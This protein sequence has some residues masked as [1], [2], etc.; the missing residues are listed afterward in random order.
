M[1]NIQRSVQLASLLVF[2]STCVISSSL[3][4]ETWANKGLTIQN[5]LELWLDASRINEAR[6]GKSAAIPNGG[7]INIWPDA[8]GNKRHVEQPLPA[9]RPRYFIGDSGP[10]VR[11]DG[12]NDFLSAMRLGMSLT[13][14]TI[15]IRATPRSNKD[16]FSAFVAVNESGANDFAT[17][18]NIDMGTGSATEL[19]SINVEGRTFTGMKDMLGATVPFGTTHTFTITSAPGEKGVQVWMDGI[20]QGNRARGA[21]AS[22]MDEITIGARFYSNTPEPA[23]VQN[24]LDG[25]IAEIIIYSRILSDAERVDLEK[26]LSSKTP[27]RVEGRKLSPLVAVTNVPPVQVLVSGFTVRQL[28]IDLNNINCV[29]YRDDGKLVALGYDGNIWLLSDKDGDGLE[30]TATPFWNKQTLNAPIGLALTPPGYAKGRGVFVPAKK[31]VVLIVDTNA[32][33]VA[34]EEIVIAKDWPGQAF[35]HGVDSLGIAADKDGSVYFGV[36]TAN[37]ADAYLRDKEGKSRYDVK[38]ERSTIMKIAPDFSHREI[39]CTGIRFPVALAINGQGDLFCTDQEGATWLPNGNPFDELLHI[40]RD[41]HYGFP[42][43]HP[44]LLPNVLDEPSTFDYAPQHQSA[45][46]LNFNEPVV[47]GGGTFGP[48]WWKGDAFVCGYSRGKIWRTKLVKTS[49][50][51]VAQNQLI[52][53]LN[54]LTVDACV[55]PKGDLVVSVHSGAPDWGSGPTGKGK[56][57]KIS[58]DHKAAPQPV[59]IYPSSE[60][61]TRIEFDRALDPA[62]FKNLTKQIKIVQGRYAAAG[63]QFEVLRPGYQVVQDQMA[64]MR[65]ELEVQ[66]AAIDADGRTLVVRTAP[67]KHAIAYAVT[68]P[69]SQAASG[70]NA[71]PQVATTDL[72]HDLTG[73]QGTWSDSRGKMQWQGWLPHLNT[74]VAK[75]FT[76][77]AASHTSLWSNLQKNGELRLKGRLDL[78]LMLRTAVQPGAKLD[79]EYPNE[80]VTV[81][82]KSKVPLTVTAPGSTVQRLS[83]TETHL[84]VTS[85]RHAWTAF[86]VV[87]KTKQG[88]DP[89]LE[90]SWFTAEYSRQRSI[91]LRRIFLPFAEPEESVTPTSEE[92]KIPELAGGNWLRGQK[93]F[94]GEQASCSKCHSMSGRGA[95]IGPDLSNLS[96]RD[97]ASVVKDITQPSAAINP[98]HVS[99][100]VELKNGDSFTGLPVPGTD[101]TIA[102]I[103]AGLTN[104]VS[105]DAVASMKPSPISLMPEG[106]LEG[107]KEQQR[108]DLLTFLLMP[109]PLSPAELE[110]SGEPTPQRRADIATLVAAKAS[111]K[112]KPLRIL[113]AA[114]P[115]DHGPGEHDYPLWQKRWSKLLPL[116]ENVTID[117]SMEWPTAEQFSKSDVIVFYSNNPGWSAGRASE[118]D[119]FLN[120]GGGLVYIHYAV[121]GHD[122]CNELAQR[123]GLAWRGGGSRFRHGPLDLK[124]TANEI[125]AG[126]GE[127]KLIDESYWQ[128]VG[129]ESSI[130]ILASGVE[131]GSPRPLIWTKEQGK[132]R[133]F[134]SIPGHYTWTFDDPLFRLLLLR[135]IAWSAHQPVDRLA[136]LATIGARISE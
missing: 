21:E 45:C 68:L 108:K 109:A 34:D 31:K 89:D 35:E 96:H 81:V 65:Y 56:L 1:T 42:P 83:D 107:L 37:F 119:A 2:I 135:G 88:I 15:F 12:T 33:D 41:K 94:F 25:D 84:T 38:G 101:G 3:A 130:K 62:E 110:I 40:E 87:L 29:K 73:V 95:T 52:A 55:A 63:D 116:A 98:D 123:I 124:L 133:V 92:R 103:G 26:Y 99:Y 126:L 6:Q 85:A 112:Q 13:N 51:Y 114:G 27:T 102:I 74:K 60:T 14:S 28:P 106:L 44:K 115:K 64:E 18:L 120:R 30:D 69:R 125:T 118:L 67:R 79:F 48:E 76:E 86:D 136:D 75:V 128:L 22:T 47:A 49:S 121:D 46:G 132:G 129:N 32:D 104:K 117:T 134:V 77:P 82:F 72:A 5:G 100:N 71:L 90:T 131:D 66:S 50:G 36:G 127:L 20:I 19:D 61:E 78:W 57:Y 23:H 39:I 11:F 59:L 113:L 105:K 16:K 9:S 8:S 24:F 122:H 17:G 10:I 53:S 93:L 70:T 111:T 54:M 7:P 80:T 91:P 58:Y 4:V 43:R 97:Y